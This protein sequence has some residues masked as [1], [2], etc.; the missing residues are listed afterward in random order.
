MSAETVTVSFKKIIDRRGD[1][2][3]LDLG[4][5][6]PVLFALQRISLDKAS[7]TVTAPEDLM[8]EKVAEARGTAGR[9]SGMLQVGYARV[10]IEDPS[11]NVQVGALRRAGCELI[12]TD[13]LEPG[14]TS[15]PG[16]RKARKILRK[17]D[18]LV[19]CRLDRLVGTV[20]TLVLFINE[21]AEEGVHFRSLS[22]AIDTTAPNSHFFFDMISLL[23]QM[24]HELAAEA[25]RILKAGQGAIKKR[26]VL[27]GRGRSITQGQ[28]ASAKQLLTSG[29]SS[30][31]Y[32]KIWVYPHRRSIAIF[33]L[34][35][36]RRI[37]KEETKGKLTASRVAGN[38]ESHDLCAETGRRRRIS[39]R[40]LRLPA[41]PGR[42]R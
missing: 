20:R 16:L 40:P 41:F 13:T 34:Q 30:E 19:V 21:L 28:I 38:A 27:A 3:K 35:A 25:E 36:L 39:D 33:R 15:R 9:P 2:V 24:E 31:K 14:R 37:R 23:A 26:S 1:A 29:M 42:L 8:A 6:T 11:L 4:E 17:G 32:R 12:Y 7:S 18:A 10:S 5:K 22:E